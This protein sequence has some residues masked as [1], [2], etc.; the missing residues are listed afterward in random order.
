MM[1]KVR[2]KEQQQRDLEIAKRV[3]IEKLQTVY[4]Q[5]RREQLRQQE[6][7][8]EQEQLREEDQLRREQEQLRR[9]QEHAAAAAARLMQIKQEQPDSCSSPAFRSSCSSSPYDLK[10][11]GESCYEVKLSPHALDSGYM[12][13]PYSMGSPGGHA[14]SP[15]LD[16]LDQVLDLTNMKKRAL[17]PEPE[18]GV[19]GAAPTNSYRRH[20]MKMYKSGGSSSSTGSGTTLL[21][22]KKIK[23]FTGNY[24]VDYINTQIFTLGYSEQFSREVYPGSEFFPSLDPRSKF[25]PSR[26][27]IT[28]FNYFNPENCFCKLS[29]I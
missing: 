9:E 24:S 15:S 16:N 12:G 13:S 25:F 23:K 7:Q 28:D 3:A 29:E 26:I 4:A 10:L 19:G 17:S 2:A 14:P 18:E 6:Q 5:Q 11:R 22:A 27:R 8:R 21:N 20:K 1:E